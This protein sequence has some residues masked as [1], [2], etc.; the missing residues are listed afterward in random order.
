M[1]DEKCLYPS[2]GPL[3]RATLSLQERDYLIYPTR[4]RLAA[5]FRYARK[6]AYPMEP[7]MMYGATRRTPMPY[8]KL[9]ASA[10]PSGDDASAVLHMMHWAQLETS[11]KPKTPTSIASE[12]NL[13]LMGGLDVLI[14]TQMRNHLVRWILHP[15]LTTSHEEQNHG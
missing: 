5:F 15:G 9:P 6:T 13:F 11:S 2:P 1:T 12:R 8:R 14:F 7:R 3:A 4:L 10:C